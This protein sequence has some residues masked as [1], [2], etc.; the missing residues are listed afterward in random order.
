[1]CSTL[2]WLVNRSK[3]AKRF[4]RILD[5]TEEESL[6]GYNK[7]LI[8]ERFLPMVNHMISESIRSSVFYVIL[9]STTTLGSIMVPAL[10]SIEENN[11]IINSTAAEDIIY[12]HNLYWTIW[13]LS[14]AVSLSNAIIQLSNL[15]KKYVMRQI[16]V[17][18][19]KKEGWLFLGKSGNIYN[20]YKRKKH[21]EFINIFWDRIETFRFDQILNNLAFDR[22]ENENQTYNENNS[23]NVS[24]I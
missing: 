22:L 7:L 17:S 19:M 21:D 1:M 24:S 15:D 10:L 11:I 13:G 16:H 2:S 3:F 12:S 23:F 8:N 20:K 14:L 18:Q 9:Q 5:K 6:S 4:K